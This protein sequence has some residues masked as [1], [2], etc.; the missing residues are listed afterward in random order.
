MR[1]ILIPVKEFTAAKKRL[2]PRFSPEARASLAAALCADF[3]ATIARVRGADRVYVVSKEPVALLWASEYGWST[4]VEREQYSES[5]SV[6]VAARI[7]ESEGVN[8]LLRIP[9]DI[10]LAEP[11]DVEAVLD[12]WNRTS[13]AGVI[14]PSH[15]GSG[16]NALLRSPP[17]LFSSHFGRG[18]FARHVAEAK[19]AGVTLHVLPSPRIGRDIDEVEDIEILSRALQREGAT[20]AWLRAQGL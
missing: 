13:P 6:D 14:V 9:A 18:S 4:I 1:A 10:P 11:E 8:A 20:K 5:Q 19:K 2:T 7:C 17:T 15:D 3:F 16:T 12:A